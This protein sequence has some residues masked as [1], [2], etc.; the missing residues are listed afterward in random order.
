MEREDK[1]MTN[2]VL[3]VIRGVFGRKRVYAYP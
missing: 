3:A 2:G 1:R